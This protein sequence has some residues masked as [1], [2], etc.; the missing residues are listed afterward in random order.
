ML[1]KV[2]RPLVLMVV[3][4]WGVSSQIS[5]ARPLASLSDS[6]TFII[7]VAGKKLGT[8]KFRILP[9]GDHLIAKA[10]IEI[11]TQQAGKSMQLQSFPRL[12]LDSHLRPL[13][14]TWAQKGARRSDLR[15]DFTTSPVKAQYHTV[16]GRN[17]DRDFVLASDVVVLD[18]NVLDQYEIL[19]DRYG[20]T[21]GGRQ[22][23]RAIIPQEASPGQVRVVDM[24]SRR[25][26]AGAQWELLR[27]FVVTTDLAR[28]D[29]WADSQGHLQ[30]VSVPALKFNAV[31]QE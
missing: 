1:L 27:H 30:R 9:S 17:D 7:S 2:M 14:Y 11:E 16:N 19:L 29:L 15:I 13:S 18:D 8:E 23:F 26:Q 20:M 28:I 10:D 4:P 21:T 31:R 24:G 25:V 5:I 12:V 3:F 22:I 6:G